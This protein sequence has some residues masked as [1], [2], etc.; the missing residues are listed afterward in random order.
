MTMWRSV[1]KT[2]ALIRM[3]SI[4]GVTQALKAVNMEKLSGKRPH[5]L[6][7]RRKTKALYCGHSGHATE[8][9]GV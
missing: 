1:R 6:S 9:R 4:G 5:L 3:K 2:S 7:R 8:N